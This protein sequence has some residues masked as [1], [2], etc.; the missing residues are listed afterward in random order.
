MKSCLPRNDTR[1]WIHVRSNASG[2]ATPKNRRIFSTWVPLSSPAA[3][4]PYRRRVTLSNL[5]AHGMSEGIEIYPN[6]FQPRDIN[7]N[8]DLNAHVSEVTSLLAVRPP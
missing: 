2:L 8:Y 1:G 5:R 3:M 6:G 7:G 4:I